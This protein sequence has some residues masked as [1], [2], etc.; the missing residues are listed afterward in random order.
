MS[1]KQLAGLGVL[2][3]DNE[4]FNDQRLIKAAVHQFWQLV[5]INVRNSTAARCWAITKDDIHCA[6]LYGLLTWLMTQDRTAQHE[7]LRRINNCFGSEDGREIMIRA[8]QSMLYRIHLHLHP[9]DKETII[10][11]LFEVNPHLAKRVDEE[12]PV[13]VIK[14]VRSFWTG[15]PTGL[16]AHDQTTGQARLSLP[17]TSQGRLLLTGPSD[18]SKSKKSGAKSI[19][20]T[21][22]EYPGHIFAQE[23]IASNLNSLTANG[24]AVA[25]SLQTASQTGKMTEALGQLFTIIRLLFNNN[26]PPEARAGKKAAEKVI[27]IFKKPDRLSDPIKSTFGNILAEAVKQSPGLRPSVTAGIAEL[28]QVNPKLFDGLDWEYFRSASADT[29]PATLK[30]PAIQQ[31]TPMEKATPQPKVKMPEGDGQNPLAR[32]QTIFEKNEIDIFKI[33][34][35][36]SY[37][38]EWLC[39]ILCGQADPPTKELQRGFHIWQKLVHPDKT[40]DPLLRE[41]AKLISN[42][43]DL[44]IKKEFI[45]EAGVRAIN[46]LKELVKQL[47]VAS[48]ITLVPCQGK[49]LIIAGET[50]IADWLDNCGYMAEKVSVIINGTLIANFTQSRLKKDDVIELIFH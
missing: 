26:L 27:K 35:Y 38:R 41:L 42:I 43:Y 11:I 13:S 7:T 40:P 4:R 18:G 8:V 36:D 16:I 30:E 3:P 33:N 14:K 39:H 19:T 12:L 22:P 49:R 28:C 45:R 25:A 17:E 23:I 10:S 9:E 1:K 31:Q 47:L 29:E 44:V 32:L 24:F 46:E 50:S 5:F 6:Y 21:K 20:E 2:P 48:S 15:E 37:C 34:Q